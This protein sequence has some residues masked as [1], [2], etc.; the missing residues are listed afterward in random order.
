MAKKKTASSKPV[1]PRALTVGYLRVSTTQ[2]ADHG[3]SLE[4]QEARLRAYAGLRDL[5][6]VRIEVDAGES[7]ST[8]ERPALQRALAALDS[9]EVT[10]LLVSKLDRLTR[11]LKHFCTLVDDY[12]RDGSKHLI[13]LGENVDT[14]SAVGRMFLHLLVSFSEWEREAAVER[15]AAVMQHLRNTGRFTGGWPPF[16]F[17]VGSDGALEPDADEQAVVDRVREMRAEGVPFRAIAAQTTNPRTGKQFDA[18][19]IRRICSVIPTEDEEA[20]G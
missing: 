6:L 19:Q 12:F 2:Q 3:S 16:G 13:S 10:V 17:A 18:K 14:S 5:E 9:G 1:A 8:L 15:T 7:G 11:N 20:Q 4:A